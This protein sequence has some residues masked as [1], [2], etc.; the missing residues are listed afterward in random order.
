VIPSLREWYNTY[1]EQ[2]LV[3]VGN[4]FP[5]FSYEHDLNNLREAIVRLD[6]PYPVL[7][8]NDG[9]TWRAYNNRYWP[10]MYLI[11]KQG[12]LR[13][14]H[15]GEGRYDETEQAI[16]ALLSEE[17]TPISEDMAKAT[18]KSLTTNEVVNVRSGP[19]TEYA[20]IGTIQPDEAYTILAEA[21]GWYQILYDGAQAY[22]S[23]AYV[24]VNQ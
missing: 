8:D 14:R 20:Q 12:N 4:H 6:V 19:G 9:L 5:E 16:Q 21:P 17:Y 1:Q 13:Y 18:S 2:G 3:V 7:Q 24:T 10:T 15:I 22:V 23:A 11:D